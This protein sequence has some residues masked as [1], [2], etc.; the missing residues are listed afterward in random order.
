MNIPKYND[1]MLPLLQHLSDKKDHSLTKIND[2]LVIHFKLTEEEQN[3][4]NSKSN[5]TIFSNRCEWSRF[6]LKKAGL[7]ESPKSKFTRITKDGLNFLE[8]H[9]KSITR[10]TLL[11]IPD[12][13]KFMKKI[14]D[15]RYHNK[16]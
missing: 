2:Y 9:P 6:Y 1:I 5:K 7:I 16:K 15:K 12:F 11:E 10:N 8:S 3:M 13:A 4:T 14:Y